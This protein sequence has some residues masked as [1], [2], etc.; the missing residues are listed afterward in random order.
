M[1]SDPVWD[2]EPN[3]KAATMPPPMSNSHPRWIDP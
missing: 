1:V 2:F 3:K